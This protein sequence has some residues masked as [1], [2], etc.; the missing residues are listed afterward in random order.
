MQV[1]AIALWKV[2]SCTPDNGNG[3]CGYACGVSRRRSLGGCV[4]VGDVY[5]GGIGCIVAVVVVEVV[6]ALGEVVLVVFCNGVDHVR[7]RG[8]ICKYAR[9]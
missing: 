8:L 7:Q 1:L 5:N 6:L 3:Y 4:P 9:S 2:H